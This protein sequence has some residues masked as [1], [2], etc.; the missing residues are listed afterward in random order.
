M[1]DS[2]SAPGTG[3]SVQGSQYKVAPDQSGALKPGQEVTFTT[4]YGEVGT[5]FLPDSQFN[6]ANVQAAVAAKALVMD[7]VRALKG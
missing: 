6:V 1:T 3:W 5:V 2:Q 7:Q 4:Q